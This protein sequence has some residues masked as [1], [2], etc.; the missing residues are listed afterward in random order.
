[1]LLDREYIRDS[2]PLF[3]TNYTSKP[4]VCVGALEP[5]PGHQQ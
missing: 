2:S 4:F 5:L 1:M 3:P